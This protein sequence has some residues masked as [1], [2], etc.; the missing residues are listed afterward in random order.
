MTSSEDFFDELQ[1]SIKT[2]IP[3]IL[4]GILTAS[5]FNDQLTLASVMDIEEIINFLNLE[6]GI[7]EVQNALGVK[8]NEVWHCHSVVTYMAS[9]LRCCYG[10]LINLSLIKF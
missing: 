1:D 3:T 10:G 6:E 2:L 8:I 4:R 7:Q 9:L 5:G